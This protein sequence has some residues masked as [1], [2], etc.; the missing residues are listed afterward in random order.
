[1]SVPSASVRGHVLTPNRQAL[2]TW[3]ETGENRFVPSIPMPTP[4]FDLEELIGWLPDE[5]KR[6]CEKDGFSVEL[7][8]IDW[9]KAHN[10]GSVPVTADLRPNR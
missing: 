9:L 7:V 10:E 5:A 3:D 4:S 8:D 6:R 1:M 2:V